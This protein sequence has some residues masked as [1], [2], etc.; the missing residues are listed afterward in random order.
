MKTK[1][2]LNSGGIRKNLKLKKKFH[3]EMIEGLGKDQIKI[4]ICSFAQPREYW[5]QKF[6]GYSTS[7][8]EDLPEYNLNFNLAM[9]DTFEE[10]IKEADII[11]FNGGDDH[12]LIYWMK[13]FNIG[14]IFKDKII[15]TSSASSD[16]LSK[17]FW[18]CD[19]R[20]CMNG[21]GF[22]PIKLI[23]H[24][25]SDFGSDDPRG[26]IDW[27]SVKDDLDRHG[28]KDLPIYALKEGECVVFEED[29]EGV[30]KKVKI[31]TGA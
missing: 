10:Q 16:M 20:I 31:V 17:Y 29:R 6:P 1:L 15:A 8:K 24:Y 14:V 11:Y 12:L 2:I 25:M 3:Q 23:P 4:L 7:I 26:A 13:R 30:F 27:D 9:P 5:E 18:T 28:D 22:L 21:L 19:W